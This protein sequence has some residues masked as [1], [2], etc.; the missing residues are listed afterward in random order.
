MAEYVRHRKPKNRS[1]H[2]C[3]SEN[4]QLVL[5]SRKDQGVCGNIDVNVRTYH[6][7]VFTTTIHN[8]Q[9]QI[10]PILRT[11]SNLCVAMH[12]VSRFEDL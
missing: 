8:G 2:K 5:S 6:D 12:S 11:I 10:G 9:K 1:V 7:Y 4:I 3:S